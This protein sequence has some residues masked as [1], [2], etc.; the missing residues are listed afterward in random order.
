M[1]AIRSYYDVDLTDQLSIHFT[2]I[3]ICI[4][5]GGNQVKRGF[6][7]KQSSND[8]RQ[9]QVRF[10]EHFPAGIDHTRVTIK[11]IPNELIFVIGYGQE[12]PF[13]GQSSE[14]IT[15][16]AVFGVACLDHNGIGE[17]I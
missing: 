2:I 9:E 8:D 6:F 16:L 7:G 5:T 12:D 10:S 1:Y 11:I 3:V 4:Q 17:T 15:A 14:A 13:L